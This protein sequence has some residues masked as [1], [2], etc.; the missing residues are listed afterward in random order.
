MPE[1]WLDD[2]E[3][4]PVRCWETHSEM[5]TGTQWKMYPITWTCLTRHRCLK[6]R[7]SFLQR[8]QRCFQHRQAFSYADYP[9]AP[10]R[11]PSQAE[12]RL[13]LQLALNDR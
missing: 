9:S 10:A 7:P 12:E 3:V 13:T 5:P 6:L 8:S 2:G 11:S 1:V 4:V